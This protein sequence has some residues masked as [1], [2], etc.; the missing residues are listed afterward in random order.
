MKGSQE[1]AHGYEN[2]CQV[3]LPLNFVIEFRYY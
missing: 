3:P 1:R 2:G